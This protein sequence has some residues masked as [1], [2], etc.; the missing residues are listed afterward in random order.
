MLIHHA[1]L[2]PSLL[3]K[4]HQ[5]LLDLDT[6]L[7][8]RGS[9]LLVMR[10]SPEAVY[11]AMLTAHHH[12]KDHRIANIHFEADIEPYARMRDTRVTQLAR[13]HGVRVIATHGHTLYEPEAVVM[14][15]K[16]VAPLRYQSFLDVRYERE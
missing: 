11:T 13:E 9:R 5:T 15:N 12:A 2:P 3:L 6:A 14:A 7:R 10:G 16:G 1:F 4:S 8:K